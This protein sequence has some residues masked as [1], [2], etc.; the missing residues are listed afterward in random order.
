MGFKPRASLLGNLTT[1]LNE[2]PS[3][4]VTKW[5]L[6]WGCLIG[7]LAQTGLRRSFRFS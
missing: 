4:I 6:V 7:K 5:H 3:G 1:E 2:C